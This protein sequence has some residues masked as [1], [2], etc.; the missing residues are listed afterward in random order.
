M[1]K[2]DIIDRLA[3]ETGVTKTDT[4]MMLNAFLK[5]ISDELAKGETIRFS[6]FGTFSIGTVEEH[7]HYN[8]FTGETVHC[9]E[10]KR[11]RFKPSRALKDLINS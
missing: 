3:S 9:P 7:D 5:V 2:T 4:K 11:I 6:E 10:Q 1:T 8:A